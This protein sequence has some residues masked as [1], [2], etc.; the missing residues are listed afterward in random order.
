[1]E[2]YIHRLLQKL[3]A[4]EDLAEF[5]ALSTELKTALHERVESL[6]RHA[7]GLRPKAAPRERRKVPRIDGKEQ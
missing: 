2:D 1:M 5:E 3:L 7:Q 6:R 4:T